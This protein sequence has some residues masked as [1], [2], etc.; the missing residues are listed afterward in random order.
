MRIFRQFTV[1]SVSQDVGHYFITSHCSPCTNTRIGLSVFILRFDCR[2]E[3][4]PSCRTDSR[5]IYILTNFPGSYASSLANSSDI[6]NPVLF[7]WRTCLHHVFPFYTWSILFLFI[8]RFR[9]LVKLLPNLHDGIPIR[10]CHTT[11]YSLY[12]VI[13]VT[14]ICRKPF[15]GVTFYLFAFFVTTNT[16]YNNTIVYCTGPSDV[17][18]TLTN[19]RRESQ[20]TPIASSFELCV[21]TS[22]SRSY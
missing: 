2:H 16:I 17:T 14:V 5:S 12:R 9:P 10:Y 8:S 18:V 15:F 6:S 20:N 3:I 11:K 19:C 13:I 22:S 1:L 7:H 4:C 21:H